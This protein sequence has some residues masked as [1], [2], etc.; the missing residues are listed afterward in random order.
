MRRTAASVVRSTT[1]LARSMAVRRTRTIWHMPVRLA[2]ARKEAI[3]APLIR[4]Q[5]FLQGSTLPASTNGIN[6]FNLSGPRIIGLSQIGTATVNT[7]R[8]NDDERV[9]EREIL[10]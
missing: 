3:L 2:I 8:L 1:L 7:L 9:L 10:Q 5:V 6:I 4:S